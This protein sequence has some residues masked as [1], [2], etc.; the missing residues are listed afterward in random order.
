MEPKNLNWILY[1]PNLSSYA[2]F[3]AIGHVD[4]GNANKYKSKAGSIIRSISISTS[5]S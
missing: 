4:D 1:K 3:M 2:L 5:L